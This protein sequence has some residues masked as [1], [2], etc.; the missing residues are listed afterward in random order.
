MS[1]DVSRCSRPVTTKQKSR[2]RKCTCNW[3]HNSAEDP[4]IPIVFD[5]R[6]NEFH[7]QRNRDK[8]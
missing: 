4:D 2:K 1:S 5:A 7:I 8:G 3:L 6:L